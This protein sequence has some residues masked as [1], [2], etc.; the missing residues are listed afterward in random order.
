MAG[1][2]KL[3]LNTSEL[4]IHSSKKQEGAKQS[5]GGLTDCYIY[6]IKIELKV[7]GIVLGAGNTEMKR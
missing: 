3:C 6:L 5:Y 2:R 7:P 4:E 1:A